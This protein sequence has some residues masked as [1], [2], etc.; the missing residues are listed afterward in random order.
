MPSVSR[1]FV[2]ISL[3][4]VFFS[5]GDGEKPHEALSEEKMVDILTDL[6]LA[7]AYYNMNPSGGRLDKKSLVEAITTKHGVTSE[8]YDSTIAYYGRNIDSYYALYDKVGI[9]LQ[10]KNQKKGSEIR[11]D[12]DDIWPFSPFSRLNGNQASEG[13]IFSIP[14]DGVESGDQIEW[15][16]R[17]TDVDGVEILLGVEYLEGV[18][19]LFRKSAAG[20]KNLKISIQTDSTMMPKRIYCVLSVPLGIHK[21]IWADSIQLLKKDFAP[22]EYSRIRSQKTIYPPLLQEITEKKDTTN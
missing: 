8:Q 14:A 19:S 13:L 18:N 3:A 9:R 11:N 15:K 20:N 5:C 4:L 10:K 16:M 2:Y 6:E 22:A 1:F 21:T 17:L 12:E 7:D